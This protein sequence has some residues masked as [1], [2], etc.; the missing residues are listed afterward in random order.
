MRHS[1]SARRRGVPEPRKRV[2]APR[3]EIPEPLPVPVVLLVFF[4]LALVI[5]EAGRQF[6]P[7]PAPV[8]AEPRM[9]EEAPP[10]DAAGIPE[11]P[12][13]TP[14]EAPAPQASRPLEAPA[15]VEIF[16]N[17]DTRGVGG[18]G[19]SPTFITSRAF[20]LKTIDHYHRRSDGSAGPRT[21]SLQA[22]DGTIFGP[23]TVEVGPGRG[24][25]ETCWRARPNVS[26]PPGTYTAIDS[27]PATWAQNRHT[28]GVGMVEFHGVAE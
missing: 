28:G 23:W 14:A 2:R 26:L 4:I 25:A 20:V 7:A 10:E 17:F 16:G 12:A 18:D 8:V 9:S 5:F 24:H 1:R 11:A 21:I 6:M 15:S 19:T 13:E 3:T 22:A 27:D